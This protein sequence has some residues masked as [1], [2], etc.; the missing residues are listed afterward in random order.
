MTFLDKLDNLM[1]ERGLNKNTLSKACGIPYT[2]I[3]GWYKKG[4]EGLKVSTLKKLTEYFGKPLEYWLDGDEVQTAAE[5]ELGIEPY[6]PTHR[7]PILGTIAAG[8]PLFAEQNI[9]GYTYTDLN[10][11]AE[12]FALRVKGDSMTALRMYDG[13]LLIVRRQDTVENDE[14]AA[15]LVNGDEATV[16]RFQRHGHIVTLYPQPLNP[17]HKPQVYDLRQTDIRILGKVVRNQIDY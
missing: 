3:D 7:I 16:K 4:Y 15:V 1:H 12:Y 5:N 13:D 8:L 17:M 14:I 11:G 10:G 9:E 6:H 2:T